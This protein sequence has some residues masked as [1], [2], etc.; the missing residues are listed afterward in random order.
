MIRSSSGKVIIWKEKLLIL[1]N[2]MLCGGD[3]RFQNY[4]ATDNHCCRESSRFDEGEQI[5]TS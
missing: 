2:L 4:T 1:G 5:G 3:Q